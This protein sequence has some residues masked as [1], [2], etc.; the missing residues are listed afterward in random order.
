MERSI[1]EHTANQ[2]IA[3]S[4]IDRQKA[5][6]KDYLEV[7]KPGI[8]IHNLLVTFAGFWLAAGFDTFQHL[9]LLVYTLLGTTLVIAGSCSLNN[10]YDRDIDPYM[11][12]T[13]NR[14]VAEGRMKPIA[15]LWFGLILSIV[16][17]SILAVGVNYL[18]AFFAFIGFFVY[19][20]IYTMWL[21]RSS[22]LNTVVGGISGAVPPLIGW[23]AYTNSVDLSAWALFMVLFLWQP[24]HFFALA[25]RKVQEYRQVGVP[26]LP[27]VKGFAATKRQSLV[28]TILLLPASLT[29][30]F[31]GVTSWLYLVTALVLGIIYIFHAVK[32]FKAEDDDAWAKRMFLYSL[33][34][35]TVLFFVMIMDVTIIEIVE[36][37]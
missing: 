9:S 7:T 20:V 34:Y 32:G 17:L 23:V 4:F 22:T 24:P 19:V 21:K 31:T 14:A 12:R 8:N 11:T 6:W 29:L 35:L 28:Y 18:A 15:A 16:G 37:V 10:F 5:T 3:D 27:V 1:S 2:V 13:R 36:R 30:F 33:L 26:M 25:M